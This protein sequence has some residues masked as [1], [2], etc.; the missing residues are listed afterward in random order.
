MIIKGTDINAFGAIGFAPKK[1]GNVFSAAENSFARRFDTL[2][3]SGFYK[4]PQD[5][6][7][8]SDMR[9]MLSETEN[10]DSD[11]LIADGA[12]SFAYLDIV[13]ASETAHAMGNVVRYNCLTEERSYYKGLL[14]GRTDGTPEKNYKYIRPENGDVDRELVKQALADVQ[15]RIDALI[16]A[17]YKCKTNFETYNRC[18]NRFA[19]AFGIDSSELVLDEDSYDKLFG[20]IEADEETYLRKWTERAASLRD[21]H[22]ALSKLRDKAIEKMKPQYAEAVRK[23][24]AASYGNSFNDILSFI[25]KLDL[26]ETESEELLESFQK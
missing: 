12:A 8:I 25:A 14:E 7:K 23:A 22:H 16:N 9:K 18:A 24:T 19:K 3:L 15:S 10:R 13:L 5:G 2:E 20:K 26:T 1:K 6:E 11:K 21:H 4:N 17:E